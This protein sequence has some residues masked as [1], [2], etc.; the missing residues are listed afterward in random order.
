MS[1]QAFEAVQDHSQFEDSTALCIL[2]AL[3]RSAN[4]SGVVGSGGKDTSPS[5]DTIAGRAH[6]HR[7]TVLNWLPKLEASGELKVERFGKGRGAWNRYT[8]LLP[9][10]ETQPEPA[11]PEQN[12]RLDRLEETVQKLAVMV[13]EGFAALQLMVQETVHNSLSQDGLDTEVDTRSLPPPAPPRAN[14][15]GSGGH[16]RDFDEE[17]RQVVAAYEREIGKI[18]EHLS[19]KIVQSLVNFHGAQIVEAITI[20]VENNVK[21]W[22]YVERILERWLAEGK[23][24]TAPPPNSTAPVRMVLP[25]YLTR[26]GE[27]LDARA[28]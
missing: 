25:D 12:E 3:A 8:I 27:K 15:S 10:P 28:N 20:A 23:G 19:K 26:S 5:I 7:N 14:G 2:Y 24:V 9:M 1:W 13:Q 18:S 11:Q 6:V 21:K 16:D 4:A 17:Y 22:R